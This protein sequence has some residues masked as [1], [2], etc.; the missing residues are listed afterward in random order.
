MKGWKNK[1]QQ[2]THGAWKRLLGHVAGYFLGILS[3]VLVP[4]LLDRL[5]IADSQLVHAGPPPLTI[6]HIEG[7]ALPNG[8]LEYH[9]KHG[10]HLRNDGWHR[11]HVD[12][13]ALARD[14]LNDFPEKVT[15]LHVDKH[16]LG[17][18]ED[19]IVDFEYIALVRPFPEKMKTF[20]FR[21]TYYGANG[22]EIYG[23]LPVSKTPS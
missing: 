20:R 9:V 6:K 13:V 15:V 19:R 10:V 3:A 4:L 14:G 17:W 1:Q 5:S 8:L 11:G 18:R 7:K 12:K 2:E 23:L 16:D 21:T 22:N